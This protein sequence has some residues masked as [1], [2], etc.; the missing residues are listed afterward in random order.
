MNS[1]QSAAARGVLLPLR[2][3]FLLECMASPPSRRLV[4]SP[5]DFPLEPLDRRIVCSAGQLNPTIVV[6]GL[7]FVAR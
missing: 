3:Q 4:R 2:Q 1:V 6:G 5:L 7:A